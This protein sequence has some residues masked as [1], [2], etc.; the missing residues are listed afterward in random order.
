MY[1]VLAIFS[2]VALYNKQFPSNPFKDCVE[3]CADETEPLLSS[4]V[5]GEIELEARRLEAR[6]GLEASSE[7]GTKV[8]SD[9]DSL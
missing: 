9:Y 6:M 7:R 5:D 8:V 3:R 2:G 1:V 4:V